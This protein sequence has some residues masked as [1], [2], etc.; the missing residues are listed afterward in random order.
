M[1]NNF[2]TIY[3]NI[4]QELYLNCSEDEL[5]SEFFYFLNHEQKYY[6]LTC[7]NNKIVKYF[8]QINFYKKER[9]LWEDDSVKLHLIENRKKYLNKDSEELTTYDILSGFKL[10]GLYYGYSGFNPLLIKKF[11]KNN[12]VK[13]CYDPCGG[14]GHRMLGATEIDCYI[15]ND[16]SKGTFD[17]VNKIKDFLGLFNVV[18]YNKDANNF[19]PKEDFDAMFTCPPY[20]NTEHYECGDFNNMEEYN[21]FID[22]LFNIFRK[23]ETCNIFGIVIREDLIGEHNDYSEK[24]TLKTKLSKHFH[25]E[26]QNKKYDEFL[27]I[28]RK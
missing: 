26:K 5:L 16:F 20:Y 15:Y 14:W 18:T 17:G 12:N 23:K 19:M 4:D 25:D 22:N 6:T 24:I 9:E 28:Y 1:I 11:L 21:N 3:P 7:K 13:I 8:Q 2:E 27:Y 10:S